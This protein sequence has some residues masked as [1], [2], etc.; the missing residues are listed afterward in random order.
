MVSITI[1]GNLTR[2]AELKYTNSGSAVCHFSIATNRKTKKGENWV[3]EASFWDVD[4]WGKQGEALNQYLTK[5]KTIAVMG[6][7]WIEKWESDGVPKLK[8][9]VNANDVQLLGKKDE[10]N[11]P[12]DSQPQGQSKP[13]G[14]M[15]YGTEPASRARAPA[16]QQ[17]D[18]DLFTDDIPF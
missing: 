5:G 17:Q 16:Q 7:A 2:D 8:V 15:G 1:V 9:K 10:S 13:R 18:D 12:A 4:L 3:D 6:S 14:D 11:R